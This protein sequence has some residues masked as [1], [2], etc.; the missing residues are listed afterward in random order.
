MRLIFGTSV[1]LLVFVHVVLGCEC[2]YQ[3]PCSRIDETAS[4]F[5]GRVRD[6]GPHGGGPFRFEVEEAFKGVKST[7]RELDVLPG[8]CVAEYVPGRRYLVLANRW[9][10][11]SLYS[12]DCTGTVAVE[13]ADEDIRIIRA[14]ASGTP[15]QV[16]RG[17]VAENTGDS[18][19]RFELEVEGRDGLAGVE[20]TAVKDGKTFT[21]T[22][23]TSGIFWLQVPE[24]GRYVVK[25]AYAGHSSTQSQ[26]DFNVRP[27][28]CSEHDVGMWTDSKVSGVLF[29]PTH[30][31]V[32]GMPVEMVPFSGEMS[33]EPLTAI[34]DANGSFYFSKVPKG[35]YLLGINVHGAT[36]KLPYEPRFYPGVTRRELAV[37]VRIGGPENLQNLNLHIGSR[38]PTRQIKVS[39]V[40]PDGKAVTNASVMCESSRSDDRRFKHDWVSRYTDA[41]GEAV[42]EVLAD[43]DF[44]VDAN[45]LNWSASSRPVQPMATRPRPFVAA[46]SG[47]VSVQITID[48][49]NDISDKERPSD[50]SG[51]NEPKQ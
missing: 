26:Y 46:N 19:V 7:T 15:V 5:I 44:Q 1:S 2:I 31:T 22:T 49:V 51:F 47:S 24:P 14:W 12:G 4:I 27:G 32:S 33:Y 28:A 37:P 10:D 41:Q 43:R 17:R 42:C 21:T 11:G 48:R 20:L 8:L 50:M 25:A 36:S 34:T 40:W 39:V 29:D 6:A 38:L 30:H 3:P 18:M 13:D 16:L 45:R 23:D 9:P 35:D